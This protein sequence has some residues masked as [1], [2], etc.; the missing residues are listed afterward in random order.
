M[1][2]AMQKPD[3]ET[4]GRG[5]APFRSFLFPNLHSDH[6]TVTSSLR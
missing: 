1:F 4:S 3:N 2:S 5:N 6:T